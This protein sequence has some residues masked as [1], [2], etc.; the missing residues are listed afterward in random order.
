MD[1][2]VEKAAALYRAA[3]EKGNIPAACSLGLC[4][5]IGSG[6]AR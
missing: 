3:Y 5:E 6:V 2:D 1:R 4:Y